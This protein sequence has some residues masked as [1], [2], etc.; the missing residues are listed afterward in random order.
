MKKSITIFFILSAAFCFSQTQTLT[1]TNEKQNEIY[2]IVEEQAEFP[3]GVG[4]MGKFIMK[5]LH[6]PTVAREAGISGK[7][8]VKFV[9]N[10]K[11]EINNVEVFKKVNGCPECD[12]EV[13]RV[14]KSMPNWKPARINN[15]PVK[16]YFNLPMNICYH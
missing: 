15:K 8:F 7:S 6:Y 12:E 9:I 3:G 1:V 13:V 2:T 11:G 10:E 14:V 16:C 5:N 4:E